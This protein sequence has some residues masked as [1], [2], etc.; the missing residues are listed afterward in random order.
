[1]TI[2]SGFHFS[3]QWIKGLPLEKALHIALLHQTALSRMIPGDRE[4]KRGRSRVTEEKR[5]KERKRKQTEGKGKERQ[6]GEKEERARWC[7]HLR[8]RWCFNALVEEIV[9]SG[10]L[11]LHSNTHTHQHTH[12]NVH[13][14]KWLAEESR[15]ASPCVYTHSPAV[16]SSTHASVDVCV[17]A[18]ARPL[19]SVNSSKKSFWL[20]ISQ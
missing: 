7:W 14:A 2:K 9:S 4:W 5:C 18:F 10:I 17:R 16:Y 1:M 13:F 19:L 6:G 8:E 12:M 11:G 3:Q 15:S 20:M